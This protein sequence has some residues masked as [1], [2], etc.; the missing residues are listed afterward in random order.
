M[1]MICVGDMVLEK[2][3]PSICNQRK[4][5]VYNLNIQM[6][7]AYK[8]YIHLFGHYISQKYAH[9]CIFKKTL[10]IGICFCINDII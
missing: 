2:K 9:S 4:L 7:L 6:E 1:Y 5:L 3:Y 10:G 8:N